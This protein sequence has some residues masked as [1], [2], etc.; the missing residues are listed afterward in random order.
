MLLIENYLIIWLYVE[1]K[2][3]HNEFCA[4]SH[5]GA[6]RQA[7]CDPYCFVP[8]CSVGALVTLHYVGTVLYMI[9]F[10]YQKL[11]GVECLVRM[12]QALNN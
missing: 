6:L 8:P 11:W 12:C 9:D 2:D 4:W 1:T 5:N 7:F 10:C 3:S